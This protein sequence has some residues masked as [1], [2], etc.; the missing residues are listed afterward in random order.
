MGLALD[1][2]GGVDKPLGR[3]PQG[4]AAESSNQKM[5]QL[6]APLISLTSAENGYPPP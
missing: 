6:D 2:I 5:E 3:E 1:A 4:L